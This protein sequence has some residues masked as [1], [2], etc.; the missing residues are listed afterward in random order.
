MGS[1]PGSPPIIDLTSDTDTGM[2]D[3]VVPI[4]SFTSFTRPFQVTS[5]WICAI[6]PP[7]HPQISIRIPPS[8]LLLA[9]FL[10][11]LYFFFFF[12]FSF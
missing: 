7:Q 11:F 8:L 12:F 10:S 2:E 4:V 6:L 5:L 1:R 3:A 9:R